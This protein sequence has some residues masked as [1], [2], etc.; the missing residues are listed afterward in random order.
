[1]LRPDPPEL[2]L[3]DDKLDTEA[4]E[5]GRLL[6]PRQLS[7]I[8]PIVEFLNFG[9][10]TLKKYIIKVFGLFCLVYILFPSWAML[11]DRSLI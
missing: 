10:K 7:D 2:V 3:P 11:I 8:G 6:L 4:I 1:M 9:A 5:W